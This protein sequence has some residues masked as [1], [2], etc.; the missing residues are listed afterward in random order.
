MVLI[1]DKNRRAGFGTR[2]VRR[3]IVISHMVAR[4]LREGVFSAI[5]MLDD[6][7]SRDDKHNMPF[8][9][10]GIPNNTRAVIDQAEPDFTKPARSRRCCSGPAGLN[11]RRKFQPM[12]HPKR[13]SFK[14]H[15][16]A[17][18]AAKRAK[19]AQSSF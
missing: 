13:Q 14:L 6:K 1:H 10:P 3:A 5:L 4:P 12:C 7:V 19:L 11:G 18:S 16:P 2:P 9:A 17:S 8:A 15:K